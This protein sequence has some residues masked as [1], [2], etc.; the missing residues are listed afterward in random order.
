MEKEG[1]AEVDPLATTQ[2]EEA[3]AEGAEMLLELVLAEHDARVAREE[4]AALPAHIDGV[5]IGQLAALGAGGEPV[6]TFTGAPA[7]GFPARAMAALG[8]GD[9]G[10]E[11]ALLFEGGDP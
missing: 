3:P 11:V 10:R 1:Q 2:D 7:E 8:P 5:V 6:V 4:A 9:V